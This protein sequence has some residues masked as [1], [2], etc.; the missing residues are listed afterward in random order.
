MRFQFS[1]EGQSVG[2]SFNLICWNI[3]SRSLVYNY[4]TFTL[5]HLL[6]VLVMPRIE[7]PTYDCESVELTTMPL[8]RSGLE[9]DEDDE[10]NDPNYTSPVLMAIYIYIYTILRPVETD[11]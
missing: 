1:F 11:T 4:T 7:P 9:Y 6:Q 2:S 3:T 5:S 10:C 8:Y